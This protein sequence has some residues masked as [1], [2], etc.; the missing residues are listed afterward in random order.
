[1]V[2]LLVLAAQWLAPVSPALEP[3]SFE[4]MT[5]APKMCSATQTDGPV[6]FKERILLTLQSLSFVLSQAFLWLLGEPNGRELGQL[7]Y[8]FN[9]VYCYS[10]EFPHPVLM[11][12]CAGRRDKIVQGPKQVVEE[13]R[14]WDWFLWKQYLLIPK[15]FVELQALHSFTSYSTP[16]KFLW[17]LISSNCLE[18]MELKKVK[19]SL[20]SEQTRLFLGHGLE[21]GWV[22]DWVPLGRNETPVSCLPCLAA[23]GDAAAG[24]THK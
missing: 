4:V 16:S 8:F 3:V 6:L 15:V 7:N 21:V 1:M 24:C 12:S 2:K 20:H 22:P 10:D 19:Q 11:N 14:G 18:N 23:A 13:K 5:Q 17:S 9:K